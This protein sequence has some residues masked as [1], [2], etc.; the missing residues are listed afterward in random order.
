MNLLFLED[1]KTFAQ[2]VVKAFSPDRNKKCTITH[3]TDF[4][5][6]NHR[7]YKNPGINDYDF[8]IMDLNVKLGDWGM[9]NMDIFYEICAID[10]KNI[11][12]FS[13]TTLSGMIN[14]YGWD[15]FIHKVM[16]H[17]DT[18]QAAFNK[19][20]FITG[21]AKMIRDVKMLES[22]NISLAHLFDKSDYYD[23]LKKFLNV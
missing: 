12:K 10:E 23:H 7:L 13:H 16:E 14:L 6:F 3:V 2:A 22:K 9:N 15:Y 17:K 20:L 8:V 4:I 19:F 18:K 21:H 1:D 5:A 11:K